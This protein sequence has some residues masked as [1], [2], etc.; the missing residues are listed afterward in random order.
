[1]ALDFNWLADAVNESDWWKLKGAFLQPLSE[2]GKAIC[3]P[4]QHLEVVAAPA[5]EQKKM[6]RKWVLAKLIAHQSVQSIEATAH[7]GG[8]SMHENAHS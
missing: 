3:I 2:H 7:I 8:A 5:T 4:P 1:M 6:S